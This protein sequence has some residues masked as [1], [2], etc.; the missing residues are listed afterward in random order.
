MTSHQRSRTIIR[1][2]LFGTT[3][4]WLL[5]LFAMPRAEVM[6]R[7]ALGAYLLLPLLWAVLFLLTW[8]DAW[9]RAGSKFAQPRAIAPVA[10]V[11]FWLG[12]AALTF[13]LVSIYIEFVF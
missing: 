10:R 1:W 9:F 13:V 7:P 12:A 5:S 3:I 6:T 11:F 4:V 2:S 8:H